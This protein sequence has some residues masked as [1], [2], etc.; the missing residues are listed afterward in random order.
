VLAALT[1]AVDIAA[2]SKNPPC[3]ANMSSNPTSYLNKTSVDNGKRVIDRLKGTGL[4]T[5]GR[6]KETSVKYH[7]SLTQEEVDPAPGELPQLGPKNFA[8]QIW[9]PYDGSFVAIHLGQTM[10]LRMEDGRRL[11]FTH[12]NRDGGITVTKWIG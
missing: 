3:L 2:A 7:L 8:G 12:R 1:P 10:T 9:C 4:V 11:Q 6:G 5:T